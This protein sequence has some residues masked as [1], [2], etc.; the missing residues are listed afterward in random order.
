MHV[1]LHRPHWGG[2]ATRGG[3][4]SL[5]AV[6]S[7]GTPGFKRVPIAC[8]K[9]RVDVQS[10]LAASFLDL[11]LF[12]QACRVGVPGQ[13]VINPFP[14]KAPASISGGAEKTLC[15][16]WD[17]SGPGPA[18]VRLE[19]WTRAAAGKW[20]RGGGWVVVGGHLWDQQRR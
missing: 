6:G 1:A 13:H 18:Q 17:G 12:T 14:H 11:T 9:V 5:H 10:I 20:D 19:S 3:E 7:S 16:M 15:S 8:R 2:K 4:T